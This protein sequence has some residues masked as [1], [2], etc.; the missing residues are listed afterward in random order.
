MSKKAHADLRAFTE[1]LGPGSS[2]RGRHSPLFRYLYERAEAFKRL[3]D[4]KR[5]SWD[6]ITHV[7]TDEGLTN[8]RGMP[9][10]RC[11]VQKTWYA[12]Q[13]AQ[14]RLEKTPRPEKP[15]P[16]ASPASIPLSLAEAHLNAPGTLPPMSADPVSPSS[17]EEAVRARF[18]AKFKPISLPKRTD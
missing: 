12:V 17:S 18:R 8:A 7:L 6:A 11:R 9:L 13:R 15:A 1:K 14:K 3:L 2:G 4:D 10:T 16:T 5:P